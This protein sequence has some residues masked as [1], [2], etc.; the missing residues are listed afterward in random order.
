MTDVTKLK[1]I[2]KK[3]DGKKLGKSKK[4]QSREEKVKNVNFL[5]KHVANCCHYGS[6][7]P[8]LIPSALN[9]LDRKTQ[10]KWLTVKKKLKYSS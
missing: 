9:S 6:S 7:N 4:I 1:Q 5:I 2:S 3:Q 8:N 10:A